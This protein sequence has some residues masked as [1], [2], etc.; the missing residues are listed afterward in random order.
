M[1]L[2]V[3]RQ[4]LFVPAASGRPLVGFTAA[5]ALANT[6][7]LPKAVALPQVWKTVAFHSGGAA[8]KRMSTGCADCEACRQYVE[9]SVQ[10]ERLER[11][12]AQL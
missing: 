1:K 10:R 4:A 8:E 5:L 2:S 12:G 7:A 3:E 11:V 6:V 9:D